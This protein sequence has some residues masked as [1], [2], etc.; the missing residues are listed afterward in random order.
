M[1]IYGL[2]IGVPVETLYQIMTSPLALRLSELTKGDIFNNNTGTG[3]IINAIN[4]LHRDPTDLLARYNNIDISKYS[5]VKKPWNLLQEFIEKE[6]DSLF[7]GVDVTK[8]NILEQIAFDSHAVE[9]IERYFRDKVNQVVPLITDQNNLTKYKA[10]YNQALDF[11]EQYIRDVQ[12]WKFSGEYSTVY[13]KSNLAEDIETLAYGAEELKTLGQILRLNQEIKTNPMELYQQV[14]R[15]EL[16]ITNRLKQLN[17]ANLRHSDYANR[18]HTYAES[19]DLKNPENLRFDLHKFLTD[20]DYQHEQIIKYDNIKQSFNPLRIITTNPQYLG[21]VE[22]LDIAQQGLLRKQMKYRLSTSKASSF[23]TRYKV[24][25]Q[26]LQQ[27]V[28]KNAYS[29]VDYYLRQNWMQQV[30]RSSR[31]KGF[32]ITIPGSKTNDI[33]YMFQD[34][35]NTPIQLLFAKTIQLGT[36]I[37]DANFKLWMETN[38][39]PKLKNDI[40]LKDNKFIQALGPVVQT[41][42]NLGMP[43]IN[44]GLV[45]VNMLPQT[46]V[47][48]EIFDTYKDAFNQLSKYSLIKDG[49]NQSWKVQDLL[50][51][52]SLICTNGKL[53][54]TALH[55]IFEDYQESDIA[56]SYRSFIAEKEKDTFFYKQLSEE[57]TDTWLAPFSSP[58]VG[59]SNYFKYK[60]NNKE[61]VFLYKKEEKQD[62]DMYE[63]QD[64]GYEMDYS[65]YYEEDV[66]YMANVNG[67]ERQ[68]SNALS[69]RDYRYFNNPVIVSTNSNIQIFRSTN[70]FFDN[71]DIRY[72]IRKGK[73]ILVSIAK[74][75]KTLSEFI[76]LCK[77]RKGELPTKIDILGGVS[78]TVIDEQTIKSELENIENPCE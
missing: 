72:E 36:D 74:D 20:R 73:P 14:S 5:G 78:R 30:S 49:A 37:G 26:K 3:T 65:G 68:E 58:Y 77:Q 33:T 53:G 63:D 6:T 16:L 22:S 34:N 9:L 25:T 52:Y 59:G 19:N 45:G 40:K 10:L 13:G 27:Q 54:P 15:I 57:L 2:S 35:T 11:I 31:T 67:F 24:R 70:S 1:Y 55:K 71:Y 42:T 43:S 17:G 28:Y 69:N 66:D 48:R 4:Y 50:F 64:Y 75:G 7:K 41:N 23:I 61:Q 38:I 32:R 76:K 29:F 56:T 62:N 46:D 51:L 44:Y 60:D 8:S 47:E 12:L 39:L 18:V 21:Y